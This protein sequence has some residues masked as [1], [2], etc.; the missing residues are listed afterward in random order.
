ML[1]TV[2]H[3]A[4]GRLDGARF[5]A[6]RFIFSQG[7]GDDAAD[8]VEADRRVVQELPT[9]EG[10]EQ[11]PRAVRV[12]AVTSSVSDGTGTRSSRRVRKLWGD[13]RGRFRTRGRYG[14]ATVR[15]T[16]WLTR[17]PLRRHEGARR[18]RQGRRAG[19]RPSEPPPEARHGPAARPSCR[20]SEAHDRAGASRRSCSPGWRCPRAPRRCSPPPP[21]RRSPRPSA[22]SRSC[23]SPCRARSSSTRTASGRYRRL[24]ERERLPVGTTVDAQEGAVRLT[25]ARDDSGGE[26][27]A[28][29]SDGKFTVTPTGQG[30]T[31]DDAQAHGPV[32][33]RHVRRGHD[34]A[35]QAAAG[36]AAVGRRP[37]PLPHRRPLLGG[38]RRGTRWLVEDRCDGTLTRVKRGQVEIEDFTI[39][40]PEPTPTPGRRA[41]APSRLPPRRPRPRTAS[42][43]GSWWPRG[44]SYVARPGP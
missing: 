4:S 10:R 19:P 22:A 14:A 29:F 15:G 33:P 30:R 38:D 43:P 44:G 34:G 26:W 1:I 35:A 36:A 17:G 23:S 11:R 31:G 2:L 12:L 42:P 39:E 7:K 8:H 13:G 28:V 37:R 16:K 9:A 21:R 18:A 3:D 40:P 6:G 24:R 25:V 32:V 20:T 41:A 5:Y 27:R